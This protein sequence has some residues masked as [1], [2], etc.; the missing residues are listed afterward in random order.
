[1]NIFL[2]YFNVSMTFT[3]DDTKEAF[4]PLLCP[5]AELPSPNFMSNLFEDFLF[6]IPLI[7]SNSKVFE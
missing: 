6:F 2:F 5:L 7:P 3:L 4:E 1:M